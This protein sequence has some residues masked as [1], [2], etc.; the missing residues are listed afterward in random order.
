LDPRIYEE[1]AKVF[2]KLEGLVSLVVNGR[3]QVLGAV[4]FNMVHLDMVVEVRVPR[5][6]HQRSC[7]VGEEAIDESILL[8]EDAIVV[9]V[10]VE[11]ERKGAG[12]PDGEDGMEDG[13]EPCEVV[14]EVC[15]AGQEH[16]VVHQYVGEEDGI[17]FLSHDF[18][19]P[20][21]IWLYEKTIQRR[22]D[23]API[24]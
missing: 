5:V 16:R 22:V 18:Q 17:G 7:Y 8:L 10:V 19:S 6:A 3:R 13:V 9:D 12:V 21:E 11:E 23:L 20:G 15:R 2:E 1:A 24:P 4:A 14:V